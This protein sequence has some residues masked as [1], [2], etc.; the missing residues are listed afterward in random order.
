[1]SDLDDTPELPSLSLPSLLL[2]TVL[3]ALGVRYFFF[4]RPSASPSATAPSPHASRDRVD[5]QALEH[6]AQ[7]LP[8]LDR[9]AIAWDLRRRG[10]GAAACIERA[11]AGGGALETVRRS[12]SWVLYYADARSSIRGTA[13]PRRMGDDES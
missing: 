11:L 4:A 7:V 3:V 2:V 6:V 9:R 12:S 1:M 13:T 8:Q 5:A 10:G